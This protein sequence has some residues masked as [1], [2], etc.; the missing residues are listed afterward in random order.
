MKECAKVCLCMYK[1][2]VIF[3]IFLIQVGL[4]NGCNEMDWQ[5][6]D[7]NTKAIDLYKRIGGIIDEDYK[8]MRFRKTDISVLANDSF[9]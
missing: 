3:F 5:V 8:F 4:T 2:K 6:L 1:S 9:I 7:W